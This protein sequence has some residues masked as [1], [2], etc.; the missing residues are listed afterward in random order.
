MYRVTLNIPG[1]ASCPARQS[2]VPQAGRQ[3]HR[4]PMSSFPGRGGRESFHHRRPRLCSKT[5]CSGHVRLHTIHST[6]ACRQQEGCCRGKGNVFLQA[7]HSVAAR[8]H[9][10]IPA[11][12]RRFKRGGGS[13][14][15]AKYFHAKTTQ[16]PPW[17]AY[18]PCRPAWGISSSGRRV[19][20]QLTN[21]WRQYHTIDHTSVSMNIPIHPRKCVRKEFS[22]AQ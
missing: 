16:T 5:S 19:S 15:A 8:L 17:P 11:L 21:T 18:R 14:M 6:G 4:R 20:R 12:R 2:H 10:T 1:H 7:A 9:Q 22:P 3:R 13:R